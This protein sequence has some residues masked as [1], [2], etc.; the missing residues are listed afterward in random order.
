M[1][2]MWLE[3]AI[4][5]LQALRYYITQD[6]IVA[7]NRISKK[8]LDSVNI[9]SEYPAVGRAGRVPNTREL[10]ISSTPYIIP[11][12]VKN[13]RIEILRVFHCAMQ[14]PEEF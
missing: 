13:N 2:I 10:I 9:L 11:Y 14:W 3:D 1:M 6:N 12:K 7:A 8:I 5:D 4:Q